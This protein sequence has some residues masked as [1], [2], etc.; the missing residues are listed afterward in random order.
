[1]DDDQIARLLTSGLSAREVA[2]QT[3]ANRRRVA[4]V[5]SERGIPTYTPPEPEHGTDARFQRGCRCTL[6]RAAHSRK[7]WALRPPP[8]ARPAAAEAFPE[9]KSRALAD[10]HAQDQRRTREAATRYYHAWTEDELAIALDY[11][12]SATHAAALL[13]RTRS[14]V[15]HARIRY[16]G[17]GEASGPTPHRRNQP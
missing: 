2:R 3:G 6:C 1:M 12:H 5:R 15:L 11:A 14:A 4:R 13:G 17:T 16:G 8:A 10:L 9:E 7:N